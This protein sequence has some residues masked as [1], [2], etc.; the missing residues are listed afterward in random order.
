M[1][2]LMVQTLLLATIAVPVNAANDLFDCERTVY[3]THNLKAS[4]NV[5]KMYPKKL[6][7]VI[8][9]NKAWAA[10]YYGVHRNRSNSARKNDVVRTKNGFRIDGRKLRSDGEVFVSY[11]KQ[12]Y[13]RTIDAT[14]QCGKERKT[15]WK[16]AD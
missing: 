16:P 13:K 12:G 7:I 11:Y 1:Y 8:A 15:S 5:D 10:S 6:K 3:S 9:E 14:Y 4:T 2:K